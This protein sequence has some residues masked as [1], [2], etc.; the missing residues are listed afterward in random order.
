MIIIITSKSCIV[1]TYHCTVITWFQFAVWRRRSVCTSSPRSVRCSCSPW[2][3]YRSS[4]PQTHPGPA[5][6]TAI[7]SRSTFTSSQVKHCAHK[8]F[9]F[10]KLLFSIVKN[11]FSHSWDR[12]FSLLRQEYPPILTSGEMLSHPGGWDKPIP[13]VIRL[14]RHRTSTP[15]NLEKSR[16]GCVLIIFCTF[17]GKNEKNNQTSHWGR[18]S[19]IQSSCLRFATSH[20]SASLVV[21]CKS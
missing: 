21:D 8:A 4:S 7:T 17:L 10:S 15:N 2:T 6:L 5:R 9:Q 3:A 14:W 19:G 11:K 12:N 13:E 18:D 1:L 20:D 16:L